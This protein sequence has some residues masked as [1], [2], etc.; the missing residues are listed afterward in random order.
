MDTLPKTALH[1]CVIAG[2]LNPQQTSNNAWFFTGINSFVL[3]NAALQQ[4]NQEQAP[5]V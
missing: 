5:A 2:L 3:Q 1:K 4:D